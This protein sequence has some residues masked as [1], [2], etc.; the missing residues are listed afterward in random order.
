MRKSLRHAAL[1]TLKSCGLSHLIKDSDWRQQRLLIVCYHGISLQDEHQWR[2]MLCIAPEQFEE[3]L[4]I[5]KEG[6]FNVL[7]LGDA[8]ER[9]YRKD[10][11]PKSV[12]LTFDDGTY[13]FYRQVYPRLRR[14][15]FPGTVY[16][17]TYYSDRRRPVFSLICSYMLWKRRELET[18]NLTDVGVPGETDLGSEGSRQSVINELV[19]WTDRE[20]LT[21]EQK[22]EV[23]ARLASKLGIDYCE[24]S[25]KRILH[26]MNEDEVRELAGQ[27]VDFQLHTHRHRTPLD[28]TLFRQEIDDNRARIMA[29]TGSRAKHFCYPSGAWRPEFVKWLSG[30]GVISAT[31]CD[32]GFAT[33]QSNPLLLP[34]FVDTTGRSELEFESWLG[35]V[36]QFLSTRK[37]AKLAYAA[38]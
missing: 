13:D 19:R 36:G 14:Y 9:L 1:R 23:A 32:T 20:N 29:L 8:L 15:G 2:P 38:D 27:G 10:L 12:A 22:D 5:L 24:L 33:T 28:E 7:P 30:D 25:A 3:R 11:P 35:G 37:R 4:Q 6:G 26:V 18:V 21:G 17:T 34:R 16:L 31:T